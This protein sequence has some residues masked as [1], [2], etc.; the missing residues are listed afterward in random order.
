MKAAVLTEAGS[1]PRFTDFASAVMDFGALPPE[2]NSLRMYAGPG[3]APMLAAAA[4][5]DDLAEDLYS[6]A[7]AYSSVVSGLTSDAWLGP[8]SASMAA[9]GATYLAWMSSTAGHAEQTANQARAAAAAYET[10]FAMTVPPPVIAANRSLLAALVATNFLGQNTPGIVATDAHYAEMWA[11]D[12]AAMYGYAGS[13]ASATQLTPFAAPGPTTNAAGLAAQSAAVTQAAGSSPGTSAQT[14]MSA[15]PQ[16]VC[17]VPQALQS[18]ASSTSTSSSSS[19]VDLLASLAPYAGV[20]AGGIG[21]VGAGVGSGA[22]SVGM[23]DIVLGIVGTAAQASLMAAGGGGAAGPALL[24]AG[25]GA[26]GTGVLVDRIGAGTAA[27]AI[28]GGANTAGALSVPPS[29]AT[30]GPSAPSVVTVSDITPAAEPISTNMPPAMWSALP[31]AQL[32]GRGTTPRYR[33]PQRDTPPR[34]YQRPSGS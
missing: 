33:T 25:G 11:Q 32:A 8:S 4:A 30:A 26:S 3:S 15:A 17:A 31:M 18:L 5:W 29:W 14:V 34:K 27:S 1:A 28:L 13:S 7:A 2:I 6:T 19:L 20:V 23:V 10:A 24:A 21:T 12:A 9:A 22:G 16:L